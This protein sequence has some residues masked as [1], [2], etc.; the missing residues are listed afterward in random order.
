MLDLQDEITALEKELDEK[1]WD[2]FEDDPE[3]LNSRETDVDR[4]AGEGTERNRRAILQE[5]REKLKEYG[6]SI[7]F[8]GSNVDE[9]SILKQD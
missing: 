4:A 6:K 9:G 8:H 5:I 2:D 1:D 7:I 3:R